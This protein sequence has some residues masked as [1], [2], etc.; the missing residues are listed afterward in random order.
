MYKIYSKFTF[1]IELK[2]KVSVRNANPTEFQRLK[3]V[4]E[5]F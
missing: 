3:C 2:V 4:E 1:K 5:D